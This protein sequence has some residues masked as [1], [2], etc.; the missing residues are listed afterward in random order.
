M[1]I[2]LSQREGGCRDEGAG[3]PW[4]QMLF[5][6]IASIPGQ[7]RVEALELRTS[8]DTNCV[9]IME[10]ISPTIAL[11]ALCMY[12]AREGRAQF[13]AAKAKADRG[14]SCSSG[15]R[16]VVETAIFLGRLKTV[17]SY[18]YCTSLLALL[19]SLCWRLGILAWLS[20]PD[21]AG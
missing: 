1:F 19:Q 6:P 3:V 12:E 15:G 7:R 17:A 10:G 9:V 14:S 20:Q 4:R 18:L 16:W 13:F 5:E 8:R 11:V 2:H 21:C